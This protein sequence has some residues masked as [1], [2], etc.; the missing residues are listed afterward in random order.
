MSTIRT[1]KGENFSIIA[2]HCFKDDRLSYRA[3][4]LL[5]YLLSKP[6]H[7]EAKITQLVKAH[8]E[9]RDAVYATMRELC[10]CGY[11]STERHVRSFTYIVHEIPS[12]ENQEV[13]FHD[14]GENEDASADSQYTAFQEA[15]NQEAGNQDVLVRTEER[16]KTEQRARTNLHKGSADSPNG[17]IRPTAKPTEEVEPVPRLARSRQGPE[18]NIAAADPSRGMPERPKTDLARFV[19]AYPRRN[20]TKEEIIAAWGEAGKN[21]RPPIDALLYKLKEQMAS[22]KWVNEPQFIPGIIKY[23]RTAGWNAPVY[24]PPAPKFKTQADWNSA[25]N[26]GVVL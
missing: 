14:D 17:P 7:W 15:G 18:G 24:P 5:C 16:V 20:A 12:A 25:S 4:G 19:E 6:N 3:I 11:V 2:N 22:H 23:L 21:G 8:R 9:G 1:E 26:P 13:D 10:A